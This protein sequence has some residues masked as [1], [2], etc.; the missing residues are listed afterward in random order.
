MEGAV[1]SGKMAAGEV[2]KA[3]GVGGASAFTGG[4]DKSFTKQAATE[5]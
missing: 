5:G 3:G 1:L 2:V 4:I